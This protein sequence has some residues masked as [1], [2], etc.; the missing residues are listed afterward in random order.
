M[1]PSLLEGDEAFAVVPSNDITT[2]EHGFDD[3]DDDDFLQEARHKK[4]DVIRAAIAVSR[5][6]KLICC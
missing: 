2:P 3:D 1:L 4:N 5:F 6:T